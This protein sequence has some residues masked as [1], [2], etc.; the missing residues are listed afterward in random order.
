MSVWTQI[1][2]WINKIFW[3]WFIKYVWPKIQ[4]YIVE[5]MAIILKKLKDKIVDT[6][7]QKS[8][9]REKNANKKANDAE[10]KA[11]KATSASE[12]EKFDAI[13]KV[14]REVAESFREE[15]EDLKKRIDELIS[16]SEQE[17]KENLSDLNLSVNFSKED[18]ILI[19]DDKPHQIPSPKHDDIDNSK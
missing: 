13:S 19:I 4:K 3:P 17:T 11:K 2:N 1:I 12:R 7:S 8:N 16:K 18:T 5:I 14:W 9:G 10:E 6:I 15:N